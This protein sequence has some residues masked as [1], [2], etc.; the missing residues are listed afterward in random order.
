MNPFEF[1]QNYL[2]ENVFYSSDRIEEINNA[3]R[4]RAAFKSR[5]EALN[6]VYPDRYSETPEEKSQDERASRRG[7]G[8]RGRGAEKPVS[9][10]PTAIR[11]RSGAK[12]D[13]GES[14]V[15]NNEDEKPTIVYRPRREGLENIYPNRSEPTTPISSP[16]PIETVTPAPVNTGTE[17][18]TLVKQTT[19]KK[20]YSVFDDPRFMSA[21]DR[22]QKRIKDVNQERREYTANKNYGEYAGMTPQETELFLQG[23]VSPIEN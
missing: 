13:V 6:N 12:G 2:K 15:K 21:R 5:R 22:A 20:P 4:Q 14:E 1:L 23:S 16:T 11:G 3:S 19:S 7:S 18:E 8:V 17:I 10:S 9:L